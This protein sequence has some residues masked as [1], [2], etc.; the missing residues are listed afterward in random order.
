MSTRSSRL[1]VLGLLLK[2]PLTVEQIAVR[3][4]IKRGT[5]WRHL[6]ELEKF[7]RVHRLNERRGSIPIVWEAL[8]GCGHP[9]SAIVNDGATQHCRECEKEVQDA[10]TDPAVVT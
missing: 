6:R 2:A 3:L 10:S 9:V 5:V 4:G 8:Q 7:K 1:D